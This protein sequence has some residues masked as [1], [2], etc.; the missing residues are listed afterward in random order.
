MSAE[1]V[2]EVARLRTALR[3]VLQ[4]AKKASQAASPYSP[5]IWWISQIV[6]VVEK[7]LEGGD[8]FM[9]D[10]AQSR[11]SPPTGFER[12]IADRVQDKNR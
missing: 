12:L 1:L 5:S 8:D 2:A 9:R 3:S 10:G 7:S 4:M 6:C 11:P